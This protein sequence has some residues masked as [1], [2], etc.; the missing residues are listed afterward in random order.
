MFRFTGGAIHTLKQKFDSFDSRA[1][2]N[3]TPMNVKKRSRLE[4]GQVTIRRIYITFRL[5][6]IYARFTYIL[7]DNSKE[8]LSLTVYVLYVVYIN[9]AIA[10]CNI[11]LIVH[12]TNL[13]LTYTLHFD[14]GVSTLDLHIS[15]YLIKTQV[16]IR[17]VRKHV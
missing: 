2:N 15:I 14:L 7:V 9:R 13:H 3:T 11:K 12:N 17:F 6:S 5:R 10:Q 16:Q 8:S 1:N 4:K